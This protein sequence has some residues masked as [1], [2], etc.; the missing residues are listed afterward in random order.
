MHRNPEAFPPSI[1]S[2]RTFSSPDSHAIVWRDLPPM[3]AYLLSHPAAC[4][5]E[6]GIDRELVIII[7]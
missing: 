5:I 7:A 2:P 3:T 6:A 4:C 1:H